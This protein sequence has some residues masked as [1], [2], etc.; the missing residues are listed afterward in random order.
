MPKPPD[1]EARLAA[2]LRE[3]LKRRKARKHAP[4]VPGAERPKAG[5]ECEED[6]ESV[7]TRRNPAPK[8]T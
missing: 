4:N 7:E 3:N 1:R 6:A 5:V 2:A 8:R